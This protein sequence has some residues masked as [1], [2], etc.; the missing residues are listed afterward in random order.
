MTEPISESDDLLRR[1]EERRND[2]EFM[3][4]LRRIVEEEREV[5]ERLALADTKHRFGCSYH[6]S[7]CK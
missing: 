5:L 4:R 7:P 3:E 1:I 2:P 6:K